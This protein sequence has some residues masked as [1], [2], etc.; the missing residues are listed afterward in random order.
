[1]LR[2]MV[3]KGTKKA[4]QLIPDCLFLASSGSGILGLNV[5]LEVRNSR[6]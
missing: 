6:D 1:M 5:F 2:I 3:S 4:V